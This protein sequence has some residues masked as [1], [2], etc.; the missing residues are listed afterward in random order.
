MAN[1]K[2]INGYLDMQDE[3][4][5]VNRI[6]PKTTFKNIQGIE[7]LSH[8]DIDEI[9]ESYIGD[10]DDPDFPDDYEGDITDEEIDDI[11]NS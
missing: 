5:N 6:L 4:G 3:Y 11:L 1:M 9:E 7:P 10:D 8:T 2:E